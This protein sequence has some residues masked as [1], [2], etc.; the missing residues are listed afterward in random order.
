MHSGWSRINQC[1]RIDKSYTFARI[2]TT[3]RE[4]SRAEATI[5]SRD[6]TRNRSDRTLRPDRVAKRCSRS[7]GVMWTASFINTCLMGSLHQ[8]KSVNSRFEATPKHVPPE[9][10]YRLC[11]QT[12]N[13]A[14]CISPCH[15]RMDSIRLILL[16]PIV[17]FLTLTG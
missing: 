11:R 14:V 3:V 6:P 8:Y 1:L 17:T 13:T 7:K 12:I 2:A 10:P 4:A 16:K 15:R 5:L 9:N